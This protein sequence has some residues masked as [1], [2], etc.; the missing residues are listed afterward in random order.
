[1]KTCVFCQKMQ[2]P[3]L[4]FRRFHGCSRQSRYGRNISSLDDASAGL[5]LALVCPSALPGNAQ[6]LLGKTAM[7][8]LPSIDYGVLCICTTVTPCRS[9]GPTPR[10]LQGS[11]GQSSHTYP[12]SLYPVLG[13]CTI[14]HAPYPMRTIIIINTTNTRKT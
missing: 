4:H 3:I 14:H 13:T 2:D 10:A 6:T 7:P 8:L 11:E 5:V 12:V 9:G 1:M